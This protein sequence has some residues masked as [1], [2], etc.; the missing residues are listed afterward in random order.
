VRQVAIAAATAEL[1]SMANRQLIS[2]Q[3]D[4]QL[5]EELDARLKNANT[6]VDSILG[7]NQDRLSEEIQVAGHA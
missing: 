4:V 1:E 2:R 5:R 6:A 7:G 3:V